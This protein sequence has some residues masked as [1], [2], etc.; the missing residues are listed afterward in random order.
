MAKLTGSA[1]ITYAERHDL[2]LSK[3]TDPTEEA[4]DGLS[5]EEARAIAREDASLI[6]LEVSDATAAAVALGSA[7]TPAKA[8]AAR[9]NVAL[10][11]RP[12]AY[13][14]AHIVSPEGQDCGGTEKETC[15]V[16]ASR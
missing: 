7:R 9:A 8:K 13:R 15:A 1:A 16:I 11:G 2:T 10:G 14:E 6:W 12:V 3:Y 5:V 4:R